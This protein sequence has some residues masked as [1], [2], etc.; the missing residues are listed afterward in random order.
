MQ[1][2]YIRLGACMGDQ[3]SGSGSHVYSTV[4]IEEVEGESAQYNDTFVLLSP[5]WLFMTVVVVIH[6]GEY[7]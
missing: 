7:S 1:L 2:L 5:L 6:G 4:F 3:R